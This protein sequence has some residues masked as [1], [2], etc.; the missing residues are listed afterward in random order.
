MREVLFTVLV[1]GWFVELIPGVTSDGRVALKGDGNLS[2]IRPRA[3]NNKAAKITKAE[4]EKKAS[5][6]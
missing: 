5:L 6:K 2:N 1:N 3:R 4:Q